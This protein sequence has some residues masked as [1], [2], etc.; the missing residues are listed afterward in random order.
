MK[1]P[2]SLRENAVFSAAAELMVSTDRSRTD[3]PELGCSCGACALCDG[4]VL[5]GRRVAG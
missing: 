2:E 4:H 1:P 3:L 5:G